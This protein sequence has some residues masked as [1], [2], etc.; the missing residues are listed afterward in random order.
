MANTKWTWCLRVLRFFSLKGILWFLILC[1]YGTSVCMNV[2]ISVS[3]CICCAFYL[4]LV[5]LFILSSIPAFLLFIFGCLFS[6]ERQKE[7]VVVWVGRSEKSWW[8]GPM[9]VYHMKKQFI[10]IQKENILV[11]LISV[12]QVERR[13]LNWRN[14]SIRLACGHIYGAF[15]WWCG[16]DQLT[17][18]SAILGMRAWAV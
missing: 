17:V 7:K 4:G 12:W 11:S 5:F 18:G 8:R 1:Y 10:W 15:S 2:F 6:N 14:A 3:V 13:N 16:R 9:I